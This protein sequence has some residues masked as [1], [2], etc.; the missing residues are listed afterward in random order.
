MGMN[1]QAWESAL[2]EWCRE[3][4]VERREWEVNLP[5]PLLTSSPTSS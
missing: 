5:T 4:A 2:P 1:P 3:A